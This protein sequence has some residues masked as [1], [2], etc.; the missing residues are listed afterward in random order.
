MLSKLN[1]ETYLLTELPAILNV[2]YL[3]CHRY[4]KTKKLKGY[5]YEFE[6][7]LQKL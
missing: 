1:K 6:Y 2:T 7:P 4:I 5:P 3:T